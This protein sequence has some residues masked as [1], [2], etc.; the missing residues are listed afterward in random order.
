MLNRPSTYKALTAAALISLSLPAAAWWDLGHAAVC[1]YGL[2]LVSPAVRAEVEQLLAVEDPSSDI[3]P[4]TFGSG[5]IWPDRIKSDRKNTQHWHYFNIS[6]D[7]DRV[8]EQPH[9]EEGD[10]LV[11]LDEQLAILGDNSAGQADRAQALRFVGHFVGDLHQ[12]MHLARADDWGG[13]GHRL[14]LPAALAELLGEGDRRKTN[15][16]AV[17]DG[18]LLRYAIGKEASSL[19][20]LLRPVSPPSQGT[21]LDW[22]QESVE[23]SRAPVVRYAGETPLQTLTEAYL[24]NNYEMA[25]IRVS[26]AAHRLAA[27]LEA[28]L[29]EH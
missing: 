29:S 13:N 28:T 2:E 5:C 9:P 26:Q 1:N 22:A 21:P 16:H 23:L 27:M 14:K 12:P 18:L 7:I 8:A 19:V 10:I 11:A 4:E 3:G 25:V 15:M 24:E 17:W 6:P 20:D